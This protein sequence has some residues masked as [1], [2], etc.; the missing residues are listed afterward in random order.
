MDTL[1]RQAERAFSQKY[2][3]YGRTLY[4]VAMVWTGNPADA[5]DVMQEAFIRLLYRAPD[6]R[7]PEHE[8]RWLLR[9]TINLCKN[10]QKSGWKSRRESLGDSELPGLDEP[11]RDL[12]QLVLA[13]PAKY[14]TAV[15][16]HDIAG[17]TVGEIAMMLHVT[18]S[19][20]KMRLQRARQQLRIAWEDPAPPLEAPGER[21]RLEAPERET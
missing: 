6:F 1:S 19:A 14:K 5:E 20:V 12:F 16:L 9:V 15:C 17:Y 10:L 3:T 8:K 2:Q 18:P 13:L 21:A 7:D 11:Q 4:R